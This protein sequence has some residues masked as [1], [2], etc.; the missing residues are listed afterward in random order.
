M[1]AGGHIGGDSHH[2]RKPEVRKAHDVTMKEVLDVEAM[3]DAPNI[4]F[5][6]AERS[7]PKNSHNDAL[8]ITAQ[9]DN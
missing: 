6:R 3:E 9:L 1:I 4:Q 2:A 7:G 5:G 8:V